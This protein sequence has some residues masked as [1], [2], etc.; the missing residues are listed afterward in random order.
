MLSAFNS[1]PEVFDPKK[2]INLRL[3]FNNVL[4]SAFL[5]SFVRPTE[6]LVGWH[7]AKS[8]W[9]SKLRRETLL[10]TFSSVISH[11]RCLDLRDYQEVKQ[12]NN[13]FYNYFC[14]VS[15][16][17]KIHLDFDKNWTKRKMASVWYSMCFDNKLYPNKWQKL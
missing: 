7:N 1:W 17:F 9:Q 11:Q 12:T 6:T 4:F 13:C 5:W 16:S 3:N 14:Q 15:M 2:I 8:I 10:W